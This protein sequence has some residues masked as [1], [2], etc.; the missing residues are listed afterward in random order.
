MRTWS[1]GPKAWVPCFQPNTCIRLG[2]SDLREGIRPSPRGLLMQVEN[3]KRH[4]DIPWSPL[5]GR[6]SVEFGGPRLPATLA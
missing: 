3:K 6:A 4:L 2:P 5:R 1:P